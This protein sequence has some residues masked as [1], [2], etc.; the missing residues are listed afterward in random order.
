MKK[1]LI[2]V[3]A[4]LVCTF[5][6]SSCAT[7]QAETQN[8]KMHGDGHVQNIEFDLLSNGGLVD[9]SNMEIEIN[10][11]CVSS[12]SYTKVGDSRMQVSLGS[13]S[14]LNGLDIP[15]TIYPTINGEES[16]LLKNLNQQVI[17]VSLA[18]TDPYW[19]Y[20]VKEN[21]NLEL[22]HISPYAITLSG[23]GK[24]NMKN[25]VEVYNRNGELLSTIGDSTFSRG[26]DNE[27]DTFY[28]IGEFADRID[29]AQVAKMKMD[30][31]IYS[32]SRR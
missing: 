3:V 4:L 13:L 11:E 18:A 14:N 2:W 9:I 16:F 28:Y 30:G 20:Q 24:P 17:S 26:Q 6:L 29:P 27:V 21:D 32:V 8:L 5:G 10:D 7:Q 22:V 19:E 25:R 15:I 23:L 1:R 12:Y 31:Q